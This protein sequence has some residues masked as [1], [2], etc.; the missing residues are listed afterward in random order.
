[1][2]KKEFLSVEAALLESTI[3]YFDTYN[4]NVMAVGGERNA[5]LKIKD[6]EMLVKEISASDEVHF[7][8]KISHGV[9]RADLT[10]T[11]KRLLMNVWA[12]EEIERY[13]PIHDFTPGVKVFFECT[14]EYA[15]AFYYRR[16]LRLFDG[17]P[18]AVIESL[19]NVVERIRSIVRGCAFKSEQN[20]HRRLSNKNYKSLLGYID[21][22]FERRS[23]VLVLRV[24]LGY[25]KLLAQRSFRES[26]NFDEVK[27]HREKLLRLLRRKLPAKTFLGH[28]W[29]LEFGLS[30]SYHYHCVFFLDGSR[31]R[32]DVAWA[33][34]IGELWVGRA[35]E[36][37]G[38]YYNC[39]RA[40]GNYRACGIGMVEHSDRSMRKNLQKA[41]VYLTKVE[42][43]IRIAT[44]G[45]ARTFGRGEMPKRNIKKMGRPRQSPELED[46]K[47][48]A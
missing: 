38:V 6:I 21:A 48:T 33:R 43:Y 25:S 13:Y 29:K 24:D 1:M 27:R 41:A 46:G 18:S 45:R 28:A 40:K 36:G 35:T 10:K 39:N 20:A 5:V 22:I 42:Y 32:E 30:K 16:N 44:E 31:L 14:K 26:L 7:Y 11:G 19:N 23:R 9:A 4:A 12:W 2:K 37:R 17:S 15:R 47:P 34:T 8:E 3:T